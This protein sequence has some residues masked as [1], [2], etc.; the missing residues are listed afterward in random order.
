MSAARDFSQQLLPLEKLGAREDSN[1]PGVINFGMIIPPTTDGKCAIEGYELWVKVIHEKDQFLQGVQPIEFKLSE[2]SIAYKSDDFPKDVAY[3]WVGQIDLKENP[4]AHQKSNWG[5]RGRYVYRYCLKSK[6]E[7]Q[8]IDYIIDP[9]AREFGVGKLSAFT[10]GYQD[11][12]WSSNEAKWKVPALHDLI[13]YELL[14]AE[15]A[16][17]IDGT[18][19]KLEYLKDLG[20]N[21]IKIM[22][23]T[24]VDAAIGWGYDPI[25]YFGVDER[26]GRTSFKQ[27]VD[28]AH[29]HGIAVILDVVYGHTGSHF[30]YVEIYNNVFKNSNNNPFIG[31]FAKSEYENDV[32]FNSRFA[33]DFFLTVN[34]YWLSNYHIDGF[35]YDAVQSYYDG[36]MGVGF[37][38]LTYKTYKVVQKQGDVGNDPAWQR[39]F[40]H[41]QD[42]QVINLIQCA[43]YLDDKSLNRESGSIEILRKT[44]ANCSWQNRTLNDVR[45]VANG[46]LEQLHDLGL[47][48]G[49]YS[50]PPYPHYPEEIFHNEDR[51]PKTALQ[52]IENHDH[53]R[54][55]RL[56]GRNQDNWFKIQPYLI[57]L[58]TAVGIPML[59]QGQELGEDRFLP[60]DGYERVDVFRPVRWSYFYDNIGK[61]LIGLVRKLTRLRKN[62]PHFRYGE[63]YLY[64]VG[65]H[66][67]FT[68]PSQDQSIIVF[69]QKYKDVFSL[70]ALNFAN[71]GTEIEFKFP[72]AGEY[73]ES[74][75]EK[76][77]FRLN[78]HGEKQRINI[79]SNYG[80]IWT[81]ESE[82]LER[83][84]DS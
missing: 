84:H 67:T 80:V 69:S 17:G 5:Q 54:L 75:H 72:Y 57:G 15:F 30:A 10:Y 45:A 77:S 48:L 79:P 39:F 53:D 25:G 13:I 6:N 28:I 22:P 20:I 66:Y 60:P 35:R 42:G 50:D 34:H 47:N 83:R 55:I 49:L 3:Y 19:E 51:L 36:P 41:D 62:N 70:I 31:F 78:S 71:W 58:L 23:I 74:L 40:S 46:R 82:D 27:L 37:S 26:Y 14:L 61:S 52:Y 9:F 65:E 56:F 12:S 11:Y 16:E 81:V 18:I 68:D 29:Q 64:N 33:Q 4:E 21:C 76:D 1:N 43:E 63:H 2:S 59:W 73:R 24:N 32:N 8:P 38:N 7:E 44:Y